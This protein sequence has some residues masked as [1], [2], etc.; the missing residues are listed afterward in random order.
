MG[1][2]RILP[3]EQITTPH[4]TGMSV[5]VNNSMPKPGHWPFHGDG[6]M[7]LSQG[8]SSVSIQPSEPLARI[9]VSRHDDPHDALRKWL[10]KRSPIVGCLYFL[11]TR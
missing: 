4:D 2:V 9:L 7:T 8:L 3:S 10:A 6:T 1:R 11:I 5:T